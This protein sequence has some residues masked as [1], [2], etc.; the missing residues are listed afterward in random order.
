M[1]TA[2]LDEVQFTPSFWLELKAPP[3]NG[4]ATLTL[5]GMT[6]YLYQV[7]VSSNLAAWTNLATVTLTNTPTV[8]TDPTAGGA[9]RFYRLRL[10]P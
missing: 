9:A 1:D 7:Q 6:G 2:W 3:S 4:T 10:L 5:N 8:I